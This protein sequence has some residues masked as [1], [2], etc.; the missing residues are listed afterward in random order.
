[1]LY[2]IES[3]FVCF[4]CFLGVLANADESGDC[5]DNVKWYYDNT[6]ATLTISGTGEMNNYSSSSPPPWR[7]LLQSI[8][9]VRVERGVTT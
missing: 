6:K 1:M 7:S 8:A 9:S 4:V 2:I 5:G 3:L